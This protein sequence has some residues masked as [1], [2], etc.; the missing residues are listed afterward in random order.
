MN[1]IEKFPPKYYLGQLHVSITPALY[2]QSVYCHI[3]YLFCMF[4]KN[5]AP[6]TANISH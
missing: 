1:V 5:F 3:I 2:I 6:I 4:E